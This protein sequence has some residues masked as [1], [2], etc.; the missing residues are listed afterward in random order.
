MWITSWFVAVVEYKT[1]LLA[2]ERLDIF[3]FQFQKTVPI[4][5]LLLFR[6][7]VALLKVCISCLCFN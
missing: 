2:T 6:C 1:D 3:L 4:C 7:I 5:R